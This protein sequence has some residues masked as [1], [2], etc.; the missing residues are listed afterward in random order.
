MRESTTYQSI[1]AEGEA[2][3][4]IVG[5]VREAKALLLR[6]GTRRFGL[7]STPVALEI[8]SIADLSQLE[9]LHEQL[10]DAPSWEQLLATRS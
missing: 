7:P 3:G 4:E 6:V 8:E 1:L 2:K 9:A 5:R 10:I